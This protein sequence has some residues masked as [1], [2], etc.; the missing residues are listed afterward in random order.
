MHLYSRYVSGGFFLNDISGAVLIFGKMCICL[1]CLLMS[2]IWSVTIYDDY[3]VL[4]SG[5]LSEISFFIMTGVIV[6]VACLA[7]FMFAPEYAIDSLY[8]LGECDGVPV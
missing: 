4:P 3:I 2:G 8:L 5:I 1:A 7:R 6:G